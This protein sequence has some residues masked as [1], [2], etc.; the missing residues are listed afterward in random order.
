MAVTPKIEGL[1][2]SF[3]RA[4]ASDLST[5]MDLNENMKS[6]EERRLDQFVAD[7]LLSGKND[8]SILQMGRR[9][10][11]SAAGAIQ[12]L[13]LKSEEKRKQEDADA[14]FRA[15]L[16]DL[17]SQ[18]DDATNQRRL[19]EGGL[20]ARYGEDFVIDMAVEYLDPK[21]IVRKENES[22]ADYQQRMEQEL[23]DL[24]LM[25]DGTIKPEYQHTEVGQWLH[26]KQQERDISQKIDNHLEDGI[27]DNNE[28]NQQTQI[29]AVGDAN[30]D[31]QVGFSLINHSV[32]ERH[33]AFVNAEKAVESNHISDQVQDVDFEKGQIK[34]M[35]G[36]ASFGATQL[37]TNKQMISPEAP[38][39]AS[40]DMMNPK[41]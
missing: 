13:N 16:R 4:I 18:L 36:N 25:P 10:I 9:V 34:G 19:V 7:E 11:A 39:I 40:L 29:L 15:V 22:D 23:S 17:K 20:I 14:H 21:T 3:H 8:A 27:I 37:D 30:S 24:M 28:L 1:K 6:Y 33:Q 35:F 38:N 12:E 32:S 31:N 41:S 26:W 5:R 2:N